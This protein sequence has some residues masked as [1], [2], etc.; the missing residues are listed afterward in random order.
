MLI[1]RMLI[2]MKRKLVQ[3]EHLIEFLGRVELSDIKRV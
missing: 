3:E 1:F 2:F